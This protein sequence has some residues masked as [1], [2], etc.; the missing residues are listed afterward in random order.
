MVGG[1]VEQQ[2]VGGRDELR[3]QADAPALAARERRHEP[4]LGLLG[5]EAE[6]LE[7]RVDAGVIDVAAE[8]GEALLVVPEPLE[9]LVGDALAEVAQLDRLFGDALLEGHDLAPRG[10]AC[11]PDRGRALEGTVLVEQGMSQSRLARDAARP[12]VGDRR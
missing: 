5:V 4:R 6:S 3:R 1:L 12:W 9:E 2:Q 8:V 10:R 11:L 7:H